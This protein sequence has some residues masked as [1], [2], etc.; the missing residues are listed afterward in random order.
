[1]D[2]LSEGKDFNSTVRYATRRFFCGLVLKQKAQCEYISGDVIK[3]Y[4]RKIQY[5]R[6]SAEN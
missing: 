1:M 3:G 2:C 4:K 5:F 6:H